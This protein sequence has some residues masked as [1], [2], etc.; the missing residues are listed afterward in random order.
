MNQALSQTPLAQ[1][2]LKQ[3]QAGNPNFYANDLPYYWEKKKSK[4]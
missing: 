4:S 2:V 1:S 3:V